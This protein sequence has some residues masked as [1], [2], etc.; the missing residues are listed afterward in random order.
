VLGDAEIA[1]LGD[2]LVLRLFSGPEVENSPSAHLPLEPEGEETF[3]MR[4]GPLRGERLRFVSDAEGR[5]R[6]VWVGPHP[7]DP[8]DRSD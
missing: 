1:A 6:R 3:R 7:Y 5:I 2:E 8:I 4:T